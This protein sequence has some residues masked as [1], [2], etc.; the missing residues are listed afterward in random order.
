MA[1]LRTTNKVTTYRVNELILLPDPR[2]MG[3][4]FKDKA[5]IF[6]DVAAFL[7]DL[8]QAGTTRDEMINSLLANFDVNIVEARYSK[9]TIEKE[10]DFFCQTLSY[11]SLIE[12]VADEESSLEKT[13]EGSSD[14]SGK[15]RK[16][17]VFR[18]PKIYIYDLEN[19]EEAAFG[20]HIYGRTYIHRAIAYFQRCV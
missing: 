19:D 3:E 10:V 2:K 12:E 16:L 8:L 18:K 1:R 17:G 11:L 7:W 14:T 13:T 20:P 5:L 9:G 4:E 15:E 6:N